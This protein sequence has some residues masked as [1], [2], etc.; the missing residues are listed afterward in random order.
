[1]CAPAVVAQPG[2]LAEA[3]GVEVVRR[4]CSICHS[5]AL[6]TQSRATRE[7]WTA[8]IRW[9]QETQGLWPLGPDEA[10]ILDYLA[11]NYPPR[12]GGRRAPLASSLLPPH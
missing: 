5:V 1:V 3:P 7:G 6:V 2:D 12:T 8:I 9:M 10:P 4:H 11:A